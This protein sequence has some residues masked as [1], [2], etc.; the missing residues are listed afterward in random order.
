MAHG[1]VLI[2]DDDKKTVAT[3]RLYLEKAGSTVAALRSIAGFLGF[4]ARF[5]PVTGL[6][7]LE[8]L[9]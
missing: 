6:E 4:S 7:N 3:I 5:R 2:V 9:E 1:R 8:V